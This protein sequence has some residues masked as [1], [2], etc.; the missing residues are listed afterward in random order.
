M[1]V[2]PPAS[3]ALARVVAALERAG[4]RPGDAART[5]WRCPAHEDRV[6]SLSVRTGE[7]G[8]VL[9]HCHA[10]CDP[11]AVVA[12]LGLTM[13]ELFTDDRDQERGDDWTPRGPAVAT[14][15]YTDEA[16]RLLF[17]VC[18]TADKQ[19]PCWRPDPAA[20]TGKRWSLKDKATGKPAVR[21]VPYRLPRVLEAA[22][23]G[24][25][26][27]VVE[28]EKDVEA[29]ERAGAVATC[30]PGGAGAGKWRPEYAAALTG[31]HVVIVA[32]RDEP[33]TRHARQVARS[34]T[35]RAA[36]VRLVAA[37]EGKDA[38][39]H[40]AA[41]RRLDELADLDDPAAPAD[42]APAA[43]PGGGTHQRRA[44]G[45][46]DDD[47]PS[48]AT[49]LVALA[50]ARYELG[51]GVTGEP[52][53]VARPGQGPYVA[54][55]LRGG[56]ASLR[57]ELAATYA[58]R[59]DRAP[60]SS[61]LADALLVLEGRAM[62]A[63]PVELALRVARHGDGLILDLG[64]PSGRVVVLDPGD[65][66][67]VERS[68]VLFRRTKVTGILPE[69]ERGG[70]LDELRAARLVNL[71]ASTWPLAL[72]WL[73]AALIPDIGHPIPLFL[74]EQGTGKSTTARML[75]RLVDPSP[76]ELRCGPK[77]L[78]QW[79]VA[80]AGSW[81]VMLDNISGVPPW[82][83]D[84]LCRAVTGDGMV[85][86]R[87]YE[88]DD[89]TV[90]K[91]RRVVGLTSIDT[92]ALR[93]D[94]ADRIVLFELDRFPQRVEELEQER[95][96]RAAWPRLVGALLDLAA[97]VLRVLPGLRVTDPPRLADFARVVA[98]V[99][100]VLGTTAL[101]TYRALSDRISADVVEAD[102]VAEAVRTLATAAGTW[103]GSAGELL[104]KLTADLGDHRPPRGWPATPRG[105]A[106]ALTRVAPA[107]R[108]VGVQ[109]EQAGR[110][111]HERSRTWWLAAD[112]TAQAPADPQLAFRATPEAEVDGDGGRLG[113]CFYCERR[114]TVRPTAAG[115]LLCDGCHAALFGGRGT[116]SAGGDPPAPQAQGQQPAAPS[117]PAAEQQ[118]TS[119]PGMA[120]ADGRAD[121]ERT[122]AGNHDQPSASKTRTVRNP[123]GQPSADRP[124]PDNGKPPA[125]DGCADG[126]D[127]AAGPAPL[128]SSNGGSPL[129]WAPDDAKDPRRFTR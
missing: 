48:T 16:G 114:T 51:M 33:G 99:D 26:V 101:A 32:D 88:N 83:S 39:D 7:A 50:A 42:H 61:A 77:D 20:T 107:L 55:M 112:P 44:G 126:A 2:T 103:Q 4:S 53:A 29:I 64:D 74:G 23:A 28:G 62:G 35:A 18:R 106:A 98:A 12:A 81:M 84:A 85:R 47:T 6:A 31:A 80:A 97:Q 8:R 79:A 69:P 94:L 66:R 109:V 43:D 37:A 96:F 127:G 54:R 75:T 11:E 5:S 124:H 104:A 93:G 123:P 63:D 89:L 58:A 100:Q 52:F 34:L 1:P 113:T 10:G 60:S 45:G 56:Q 13:R 40:L 9:V 30:N 65:W 91:F 59:Y 46:R 111:G 68:P 128:S 108:A 90:L 70:R 22:A 95:A 125:H 110:Q 116:A 76:A 120:G 21:L 72:A 87:L 14:Y 49:E 105:M 25:T 122:V 17:A 27:Y 118:T 82:L 67:L 129:M 78:E 57:A 86:R 117:A 41:G 71:T 19:F 119:S 15:R 3:P 38:A 115:S 92:G 102:P 24:G 121:G 36:S 73:V